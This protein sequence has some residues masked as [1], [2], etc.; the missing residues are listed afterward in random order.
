MHPRLIS[1]LF[2]LVICATAHAAPSAGGPWIGSAWDF[3]LDDPSVRAAKELFDKDG[4]RQ[5]GDSAI[6]MLSSNWKDLEFRGLYLVSTYFERS[7]NGQPQFSK[8]LLVLVRL[9]SDGKNPVQK[10]SLQIVDAEKAADLL[11]EL[12]AH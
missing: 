8:T 9:Y 3:V 11:L 12:S 2:A 1:G 6:I 7:H 5:N 10:Q 4:F